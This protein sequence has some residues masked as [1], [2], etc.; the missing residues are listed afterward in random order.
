MTSVSLLI[1]IRLKVRLTVPLGLKNGQ[2]FQTLECKMTE[3]INELYQRGLE[4]AESGKLQEA[5]E[6]IRKYLTIAPDDAQALND[7]GAI[8][9]CLGRSDEA[10]EHLYRAKR[11]NHQSPEITWNLAEACIAA[12][13]AGQTVELFDDMERMQI[14]NF[15]ILNRTAKAFADNADRG[16]A[17][18]MLL[19]SLK[20]APN[21]EMLEPMLETIRKT[22][23][24]IAFF[25]GAD[26][27]NF[28][29]EIIDF[30]KQRFPVKVFDGNSEEQMFQLMNWSDI[31]WFEWCTNLAAIGSRMPKVCKNIVRLHRYEAYEEWP[32]KI[33]WENIDTL[34]TVG[35][36]ITKDTLFNKVPNLRNMT[37]IVDIPN[38]IDL[39]KFPFAQRKKGKNIAFLANLR[40]VKNPALVLQCMQKLNY[41]DR[42]YRL[43]F[44]GNFQDEVLEQ[45][46]RHMVN[47]LNLR[48]VVFFDGWQNDVCKWL[49]DKHYIVSTSLCEGHPVGILEA[50]ARGLKPVIHNFLGAEQTFP[51]EYLFNISEQ[52]CQQILSS[53]YEPMKY[54]SFVEQNCSLRKQLAQVK[55]VFAGFEADFVPQSGWDNDNAEFSRGFNSSVPVGKNIVL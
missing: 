10:L 25:C 15:D 6:N 5:L 32:R 36:N 48:D 43:F 3:K 40:M 28:L 23:P 30:T 14:L 22:R 26:G 33:N 38:G 13:K 52:F 35:N 20:I 18:E 53:D 11:L 44:A 2:I 45:Y 4:L 9:H 42:D 34:I 37:R 12:G 31:S 17:I 54:R 21:Q 41:L 24:K 7:T 55:D 16:G 50:M 46:L 29:N 49:E 1:G 51:K 39:D 47:T 8:L 27:M 19:R